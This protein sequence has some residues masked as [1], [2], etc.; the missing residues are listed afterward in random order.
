MNIALIFAGGT[1]QRMNAGAVP[2]QFLKLHGKPIIIYTIEQFENHTQIDEIVVV[3]LEK[4]IPY[5]KKL[6]ENFCIRKV[7]VIVPG[8]K[9]GQE[10]IYNG[11]KVIFEKFPSDS[12]VL[13]HDGVRPLIDEATI[14]ANI[15][16]VKQYGNAITVTPAI[17][18][19]A[20]NSEEGKIERFVDRSMCLIAKAPQSFWVR[21]LFRCHQKAIEENKKSF[22]DSASLMQYYGYSLFTVLG[23]S[24]NIKITTPTDF[25]IF[26][27]IADA[28]E[29][30][31][32]MGI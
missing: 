27:A 20:I 11:I 24:E 16:S 15:D 10:S 6:L 31:Q 30:E 28:K 18:T 12:I 5:L 2:K 3:C 29:N 25:Y 4:W 17:E 13:V 9:T 26:R 32:I 22:I 8:G 21:D 7:N 19:I 14:T 1:G 23:K